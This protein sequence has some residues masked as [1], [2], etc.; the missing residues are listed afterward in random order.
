MNQQCKVCGEPAAGFHFGAF[1]CEGCKS[2]FGRSYNNLS[3][4]SE[5]KNNGECIINKKNRT[6]CKAC[7]LRKCLMVGMSKSGSRYGRR[8]NWFKIHCLLQEQQQAAQQHQQQHQQHQ[9]QGPHQKPPPPPVGMHPGMFHGAS[10]YGLYARPPCTKEELM[11]LGLEEYT[12]HP[13]S[14][15]PSVSSPDSHNS[16]SSNEI[17]DRRHALLRQ[18]KSLHH[19]SGLGK[20]LFLPL[21]FGGLP[22][23]PPP[24]FLPSSHLMFPG[25]HPAL[26]SHPQAGLLKPADGPHLTLPSSPL[27]NNNNS[28]FTPNHNT[29]PNP[30]QTLAAGGGGAGPGSGGDGRGSDSGKSPDSYSKRFILDQVLESQ[31]CPSNGTVSSDKDEPEPEEVG[32]ATMT[33]PRSPVVSVVSQP[34]SATSVRQPGH[35]QHHHQNHHH[36]HHNHQQDNPIDLSMKTGSS[37]TSVDDRRSSISGAE[38]N[39]SD[40]EAATVTAVDS[41]T[42][43]GLDGYSKY[44]PAPAVAT[45]T[46]PSNNNNNNIGNHQAPQSLTP[47]PTKQHLESPPVHRSESPQHVVRQHHPPAHHPYHPQHLARRHHRHQALGHLNHHHHHHLQR[48]SGSESDLEPD[49]ETEYDREVNRMKLQGTTPLDLTTKV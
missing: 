4:I 44:A 12:K 35:H 38:S 20:D 7:R 22:L 21:P 46:A 14:A 16:D 45:K 26:Y 27:A 25:F 18:G 41:R 24:G 9:G 17:N 23:M 36:H 19:D 32:P 13:A 37:C 42:P 6:A 10:P 40:D 31:R 15:S 47:S 8:S 34:P 33:P 1:T 48:G 28:R 43:P 39:G 49:L 11:L 2:F 3:S 29:E 5:C 30:H